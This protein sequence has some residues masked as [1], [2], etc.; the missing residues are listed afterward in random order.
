MPIAALTGVE[1]AGA[2]DRAAGLADGRSPPIAPA[3]FAISEAEAA[4]IRAV[5][6]RSLG[7]RRSCRLRTGTAQRSD[8]A[9]VHPRLSSD[10][11]RVCS[12]AV[13]GRGPPILTRSASNAPAVTAAVSASASP[14]AA[15]SSR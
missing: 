2:Q 7:K 9:T 6:L 14:A 5:V 1:P 13:C 3:M 15:A 8:P 11:C 10:R 4:A 12:A